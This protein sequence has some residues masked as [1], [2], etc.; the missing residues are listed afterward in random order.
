MKTF[1]IVII[2]LF[3][4]NIGIVFAKNNIL[5][6]NMLLSP[7]DIKIYKQIFIIQSK[8]IQNRNNCNCSSEWRKVDK[9]IKKIDNKILLGTVFAERYLHPTGWRSS[10]KQLKLWL[11]RYNDHPDA[12]RIY[13]IASKR[14]PKN[15]KNPKIQYKD[16]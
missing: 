3:Q 11:D 2:A 1:F 12:V 16:S 7:E 15:F 9:L 4:F 13:R 10:Y 5:E 6:T 8:P 14:K